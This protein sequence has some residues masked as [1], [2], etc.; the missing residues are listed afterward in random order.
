[1]KP[2][3]I[4]LSVFLCLGLLF[5]LFMPVRADK[6]V[7]Y[8]IVIK[9]GRVLDPLT[10]ADYR[11]NLGIKDGKIKGIFPLPRDEKEGAELNAKVILDAAGLVVAPGFI[12]MHAH[13]GIL[14]K[15]MEVFVRDGRTTMIGGNCGG[16]RGRVDRYLTSLDK[17]GLFI[18]YA[19]YSGHSS[20]RM[21]VGA[22]DRYEAATD[23]QIEAMIPL[24]EQDMNA[25]ALGVSYGINYVPGASYKEVLALARVSA[26]YGG[27]T[28]AHGRYGQNS[29]LSVYSLWE[30]VRLTKDTGIPH[31]YS[32]IGS[33]LGY[34]DFMNE[35]LELLEFAQAKGL[36]MLADIYSYDAWSTGLGSAI[37]DEGFFERMNCKPGDLEAVSTVVVDGKTVMKSGD[38]FTQE[39][40]DSIRGLV[41][42]KKIADP[43]IIGHVIRPDK[44]QLAMSNPFVVCGSDG[45]ISYDPRTKKHV[46][47][48]RTTNNFARFLGLWVREK[49]TVDLMTALFKTSTQSALHLGLTGKGRIAVGADAD[50]TVFDPASIIDRGE[51]GEGFDTPPLG[52]EYV[53]VNGVLAVEKGKLVPDITPGRT[54]R[55]TWKVPGYSK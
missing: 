22:K 37:L 18:N 36:R 55:R 1:M 49:G 15:T 11:A 28:A 54:I 24:L 13:E 6:D 23:Q 33:M 42:D 5:V 21:Q 51:F 47:H 35:G 31:Q 32:H 2:K 10:R 44:V 40:F 46:G 19:T 25:G 9:N 34:G 12:D 30:M 14:K 8:D 41:V 53:L 43:G 39:L 45:G 17:S 26:R 20:L 29:P 3:K 27:M 50:I 38:R 4:V 48:P 16:S 52:I 7:T